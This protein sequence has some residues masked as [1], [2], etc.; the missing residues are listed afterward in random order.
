MAALY[1]DGPAPANHTIS[2]AVVYAFWSDSFGS[3]SVGWWLNVSPYLRT[4]PRQLS[5]IVAGSFRTPLAGCG[6]HAGMRL[7][8]SINLCSRCC[9]QFK[10]LTLFGQRIP[11]GCMTARQ[12]AKVLAGGFQAFPGWHVVK[13]G[14]PLLFVL[15]L[16][17]QQAKWGWTFVI[18]VE[19]TSGAAV[20]D[21]GAKELF[22]FLSFVM[23]GPKV[24][25]Y[26]LKRT[27]SG[28]NLCSLRALCEKVHA[29][30]LVSLKLAA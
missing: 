15:V 17:F 28:C 19:S 1:V 12:W 22:G 30:G 20:E 5:R 11:M 27:L 4:E 21:W 26:H 24:A 25:S 13:G 3:P 29:V 10:R 8:S 6:A 16:L 23:L 9:W 14:P 2:S 18:D 7:H